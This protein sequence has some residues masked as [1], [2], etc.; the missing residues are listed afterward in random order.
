MFHKQKEEW[1]RE[2]AAYRRRLSEIK[3]PKNIEPS[4]GKYILSMLDD[5]YGDIRL[6]FGDIMKQLDEAESLIERIRRK[7]E[8]IGSN[9]E[10]RKANGIFAVENVELGDGAVVDLY[11]IR[12][13]LVSQKEDLSGLLAVIEKKQSMVITMSGLLKI[14]S[15]IS[16]H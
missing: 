2:I 10:A 1:V 13:T 11:A 15:N 3:I 4:Q 9:T 5:L 12:T 7:A 16:G 14:E 8:A 6:T